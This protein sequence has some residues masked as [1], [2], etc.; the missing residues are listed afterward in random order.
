MV[1]SQEDDSLHGSSLDMEKK[2]EDLPDK[3]QES[4]RQEGEALED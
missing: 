4:E 2:L 1:H 3:E